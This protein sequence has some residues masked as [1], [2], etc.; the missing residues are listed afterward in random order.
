ME[1]QGMSRVRNGYTLLTRWRFLSG[2]FSAL[3]LLALFDIG[4]ATAQEVKQIKL[5][6]RQ[7]QGFIAAHDDIEKLYDG[8]TNPDSKV[9]SQVEGVVKKSGFASLAEHELVSMNIAI[10]MSGIDPQTKKFTEP[11]E[12]IRKEIAVLKADKSFPQVEKQE[13][14]AQLEVALK[15]AKPIQF[16]ENIALVLKYFDKL[17]PLIQEQRPA[18]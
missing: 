2:L 4:V 18:D 15:S 8:A 17:Q 3:L 9:Q 14:L 1:D 5:A 10:I 6:E 16:K 13:V 12:Q 11:P 7:I